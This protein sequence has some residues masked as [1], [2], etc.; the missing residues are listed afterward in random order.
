V[1]LLV[2][3]SNAFAFL[4]HDCGGIQEHAYVTGFDPSSGYPTGAVHMSTTCSGSGHAGGGTTYAAWAVVTWDFSGQMVS[5]TISSAPTVDPTFTAT[6]ADGDVIYNTG[7][8]AYLLVPVP[9][10]PIGVTAVQSGDQFLVAWTPRIV[11]SSVVVSTTLTATPVNSTAPV[12]TTI[13]SGSATNGVIPTLQPQTTYLIT[14]VNATIGGSGPMSIPISVT[15][16]PATEPP[17]APT[18]VT[19]SWLDPDPS[20]ST[21]T[22]S[23]SWQAADPGNSPID[24]YL[25][26]ITGS[27]SAGTFT[28]TV[29]GTTLSTYFTEDWNPNWSITVQAHNAFGWGPVSN[30]FHL[31]GL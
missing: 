21:D 9:L 15:T 10:A 2:P 26:Q 16:S 28:Q 7:T 5:A 19:A 8:A 27:E 20:G 3:Q 18:G 23:V 22:I 25:I 13:V 17:G 31:G 6:D 30:V 11:N 1:S 24:Q 14:V 29:P 4:G 12:L